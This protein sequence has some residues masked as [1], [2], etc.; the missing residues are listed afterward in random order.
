MGVTGLTMRRIS[1]DT[2]VQIA[3][4][5]VVLGM[6]QLVTTWIPLIDPA[7]LP[8]PVAT[9]GHT[10]SLLVDPS[11]LWHIGDTMLRTVVASLL[12]LGIGVPVGIAMGWSATANELLSPQLSAL[13][14]LPVVALIPLLMLF[15]SNG[16][17]AIVVAATFGAFFL[18]VWNAMVGVERIK[19]IYVD[20]ARDNGIDTTR[21]LFREVLLPGALP[22]ILVGFRLC[23]YTALLIVI[24]AEMLFGSNGLGYVLWIS[25]Q[26]YS[27]ATVYGTLVVVGGIG[28]LLTYGLDW[29]TAR[30]LA[31]QPTGVTKR[32]R[33]R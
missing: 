32:G 10:A 27:I 33:V 8:S 24:S 9:A 4:V 13:Y 29:L 28:I 16:S 17:V 20:A 5:G 15:F 23:L 18:V 14:P 11:F 26:T 31:W 25:Y 1:R 12:A 21:G 7:I 30:V 19:D 2:T 3:S 6:W 22:M